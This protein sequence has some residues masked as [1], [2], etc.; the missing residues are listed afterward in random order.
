MHIVAAAPRYLSR[1]EV[2]EEVLDRERSVLTEQA[3]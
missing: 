1:G 2:D 3:S